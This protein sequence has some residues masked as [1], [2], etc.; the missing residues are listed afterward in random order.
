MHRAWE[1]TQ[2]AYVAVTMVVSVLPKTMG[3]LHTSLRNMPADPMPA[4]PIP[5]PGTYMLELDY[6][7]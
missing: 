3:G 1:A 4:D 2:V 6:D 5:A 7:A